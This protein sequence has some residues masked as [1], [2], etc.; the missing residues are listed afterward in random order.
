MG[1][2]QGHS[3]LQVNSFHII[4]ALNTERTKKQLKKRKKISRWFSPS[5]PVTSQ[6]IFCGCVCIVLPTGT[7][8]MEKNFKWGPAPKITGYLA[9]WDA[10]QIH[11]FAKHMSSQCV[12]LYRTAAAVYINKFPGAYAYELWALYSLKSLVSPLSFIAWVKKDLNL[13]NI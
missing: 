9:G 4:V 1:H 2:G 3:K 13:L 12:L 11:F 8:H 10:E 5:C 7:V 6:N